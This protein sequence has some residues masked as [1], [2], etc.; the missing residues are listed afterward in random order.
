MKLP[1]SDPK[2]SSLILIIADS[3]PDEEG[4]LLFMEPL[5]PVEAAWLRVSGCDQPEL[6]VTGRRAKPRD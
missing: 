6:H 4:Q 5:P 2:R 1:P 3:R